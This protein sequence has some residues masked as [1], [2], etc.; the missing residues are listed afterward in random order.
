MYYILIIERSRYNMNLEDTQKKQ[1]KVMIYVMLLCIVLAVGASYAFFT[2]GITSEDET[3]VTAEGGIMKINYNGGNTIS[4]SGI[5]PRDEVWATKI[6]TVTGNNT[7]DAE[8]YY[9]LTLVVD[10]NTFDTSDPLQY[11]LVSI[12]TSNNGK[13]VPAISKINLTSSSLELGKGNFLKADNAVHTYQLKIYYPLKDTVQNSNQGAAF[14]AHVEITDDK[15]NS[16]IPAPS[17]WYE[18]EEGTMIAT[19]RNNNEIKQVITVP[20]KE[21]SIASEALLASTEDD[22]GTSYY[23]RGAVDNNYVEFANKC[24][25]IVR[26][27]GD[28]SIKLI[29]HNN[30]ENGVAN[31][32]SAENNSDEAAFIGTS[33][34]N[35]IEGNVGY[36]YGD[37]ESD[38]YASRFANRYN[39]DILSELIEFYPKDDSLLADVIWCNDKS[40]DL[41][42]TQASDIGTVNFYGAASRLNLEK[43]SLVCPNDN[44]GGKLS[45]YTLNDEKNGNGNLEHKIG[46]ITA[47]ELIFAGY[48][49]DEE[50]NNNQNVYLNE[51]ATSNDWW[52]MSPA[53]FEL[54][55]KKEGHSIFIVSQAYGISESYPYSIESNDNPVAIRPVIALVPTVKV[56]GTGTSEDPY[57][58]N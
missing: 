54:F 26:I 29:L 40:F 42:S 47:D 37:T 45:K 8:M 7:T 43:P 56:T 14:N 17:G 50:D 6:I 9:K 34:F 36:M 48:Y 22:Y 38:D 13:V 57:V 25:R 35:D 58:V 52:T 39:S 15:G 18:A 55:K 12:N 30:N 11:E 28:G 53:S 21:A 51:N 44:N 5:Y 20:G 1:K 23:Y 2:A 41:I 31:P 16:A 4:L 19:L 46:L 27:T 32:C 10:S 33:I 49:L 24:W 3:T